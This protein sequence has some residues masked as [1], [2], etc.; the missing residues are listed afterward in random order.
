MYPVC[1]SGPSP[2]E[3]VQDCLK[4]LAGMEEP[5]RQSRREEWTRDHR[6]D[7]WGMRL[8]EIA[9]DARASNRLA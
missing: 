1:G 5:L 2:L 3:A 4:K 7:S 9:A 8:L 6:I